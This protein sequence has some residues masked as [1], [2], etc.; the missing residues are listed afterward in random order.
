MLRIAALPPENN[1]RDDHD[2]DDC[3]REKIPDEGAGV[4]TLRELEYV[5]MQVDDS[6]VAR[7]HDEQIDRQRTHFRVGAVRPESR[8]EC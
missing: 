5:V 8:H 1:G 3:R 4:E 6:H 2:D 7:E